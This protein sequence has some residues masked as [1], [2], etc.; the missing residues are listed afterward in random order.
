MFTLKFL[1]ADNSN[2]LTNISDATVCG[3]RYDV[4]ETEEGCVVT[5]YKKSTSDDGGVEFIVGNNPEREYAACFIENI[6]GKT[7]DHFRS[8]DNME[9]FAAVN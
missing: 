9:G 8:K 1:S 2:N 6:A 7:I 5:I 3:E 4:R